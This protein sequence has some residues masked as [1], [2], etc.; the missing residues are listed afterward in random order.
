M[1]VVLVV[2]ALKAIWLMKVQ[3]WSQFFRKHH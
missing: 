3:S 1:N 2:S